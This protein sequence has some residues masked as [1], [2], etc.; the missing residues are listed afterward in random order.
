MSLDPRRLTLLSLLALAPVAAF[1]LGRSMRAALAV[2][3]VLL[4]T[5]SLYQ[6]FGPSQAASA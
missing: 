4:I 2:V 3:C 1:L 6:M 5:G